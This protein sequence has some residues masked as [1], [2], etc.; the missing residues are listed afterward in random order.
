[1][2]QPVYNKFFHRIT[3]KT[4]PKSSLE[5][6]RRM[7]LRILIRKKLLMSWILQGFRIKNWRML[8]PPSLWSTLNSI[9]F[10]LSCLTN[11]ELAMVSTKWRLSGTA[12][13]WS[14]LVQPSTWTFTM[15]TLILR[16][17]CNSNIINKKHKVSY[18]S[19]MIFQISELLT[20]LCSL[21]KLELS[22]KYLV[23]L[24]SFELLD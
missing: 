3:K 7:I 2:T 18:M 15:W 21:I 10:T 6:L 12:H 8:F 23:S 19:S 17:L 11:S 20:I 16:I 13:T 24:C 5:M 4:K 9:T 14:L 22:L 1:M